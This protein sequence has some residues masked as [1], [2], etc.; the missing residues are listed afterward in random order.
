MSSAQERAAFDALMALPAEERT[1]LC[2]AVLEHDWG[3][4][5]CFARHSLDDA[6]RARFCAAFLPA[7]LQERLAA[8]DAA[9]PEAN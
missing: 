2:L 4:L 8:M 5:M 1:G 9:M 3:T 7:E 6:T